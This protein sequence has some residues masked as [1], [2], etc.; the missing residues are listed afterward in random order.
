MGPDPSRPTTEHRPTGRGRLAST[1]RLGA[2][3][4]RQLGEDRRVVP[5]LARV[6]GQPVGGAD[7]LARVA[8]EEHPLALVAPPPEAL[9]SGLGLPEDG[10]VMAALAGVMGQM[11]G[12]AGPLACVAGEEQPLAL[13][14]PP[15]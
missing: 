9:L 2:P 1:A 4:S 13:V 10:R 15:P 12:G 11:I 3:G 6:V 8:G 5:A 14:A 7:P